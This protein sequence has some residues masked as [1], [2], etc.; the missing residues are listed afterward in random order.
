MRHP[1]LIAGL[2]ASLALTAL[3]ATA[4]APAAQ[5]AP[6]GTRSLATVLSVNPNAA[7][8]FDHNWSNYDILRDTVNAILKAKPT[9]AVGTLAQGNVAATCF[10]PTD[11]AFRDFAR[12]AFPKAHGYPNEKSVFTALATKT[13]GGIDTLEAIV[14]YHCTAAGTIDS[15]AALKANG[16][17]LP[18]LN[19]GTTKVIV[20]HHRISLRD[21]GLMYANPTVVQADINKGNKQIAHGINHVL[22][23]AN[24]PSPIVG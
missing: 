9:S 15:S 3:A 20:H 22:L 14:L 24:L 4:V 13:P 23:P 12:Q 17:T 8:K 7:A 5:A 10:I 18:M 1:R 11:R 2:T 16:V 19:G 6:L 21:R